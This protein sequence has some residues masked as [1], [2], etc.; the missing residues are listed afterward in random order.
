MS[1]KP[2]I[3]S[4]YKVDPDTLAETI[5][6]LASYPFAEVA[7]I[8]MKLQKNM[9]AVFADEIEKPHPLDKHLQEVPTKAENL[10]TMAMFQLWPV[11]DF[12]EHPLT[13]MEE[14]DLARTV[15][16]MANERP[17]GPH[18][19]LRKE[20]ITKLWPDRDFKTDP[21]DLDELLELENMVD[22]MTPGQETSPSH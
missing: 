2:R 16:V 6:L 18:L 11:R 20:A 1:Q 13:I 15:T 5:Q 10:R 21:L 4:H 22:A 7:P 8:I 19:E 9:V 3:I 17:S 12:D 14:E